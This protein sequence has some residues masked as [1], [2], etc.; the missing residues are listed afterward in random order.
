MQDQLQI[1]Q[2]TGIGIRDDALGSGG[3]DLDR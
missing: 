1:I 3:E 2:A